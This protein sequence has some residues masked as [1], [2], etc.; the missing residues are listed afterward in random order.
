MQCRTCSLLRYCWS[1]LKRQE[2]S[3]NLVP[4]T[5]RCSGAQVVLELE[6]PKSWLVAFN[7]IARNARTS[8][9]NG[10]RCLGVISHFPL[11]AAK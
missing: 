8:V 9:V 4:F 7:G 2:T 1:L 10:Q 3:D 11:E 5:P 6:A